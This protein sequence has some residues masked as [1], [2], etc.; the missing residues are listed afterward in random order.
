MR[1]FDLPLDMQP[2]TR[3]ALTV[4]LLLALL[5]GLIAPASA[6][7][8]DNDGITLASVSA[9]APHENPSPE[10]NP[11]LPAE[12]TAESSGSL[13]D[14]DLH[15]PKGLAVHRHCFPVP[16]TLMATGGQHVPDPLLGRYQANAP[17]RA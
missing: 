6:L 1:P 14:P 9:S 13:D 15:A 12:K 7:A 5:T 4:L 11:Q 2:V 8:Q 16:Q 3:L 17:P 10:P